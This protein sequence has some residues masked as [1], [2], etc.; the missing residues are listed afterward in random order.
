MGA[1]EEEDGAGRSTKASSSAG[2]ASAPDGTVRAQGHMRGAVGHTHGVTGHTRG[3]PLGMLS[4]ALLSGA[5][6][7]PR[8]PSP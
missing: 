4:A 7:G 1:K 6:E 3:S 2:F 5:G 8:H